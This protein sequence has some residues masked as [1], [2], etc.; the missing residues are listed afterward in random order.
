L[1]GFAIAGALVL[2]GSAGTAH[3]SGGSGARPLDIQDRCDEAS[4]NAALFPGACA[5]APSSNP[6]GRITFAEFG[7]Q[8]N[9]TDNGD[10]H[11]RYNPAER[12]VKQG[13]SLTFA[14]HN[15]GGEMHTF[16]RVGGDTG[17]LPNT[18]GCVPQIADA[19]VKQLADPAVCGVEALPEP[20]GGR[21]LVPGSTR[22][23]T[24]PTS[25]KGSIQYMCLIHPWMKVVV[26]VS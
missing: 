16:T 24:V 11:W 3:A 13:E 21:G 2:A 26:T 19:L 20:L 25:S 12:T 18:G 5:Y 9:P 23:V 4:F 1:C 22:V 8:L 15:E 14:V 7:A 17:I 10:D 6:R